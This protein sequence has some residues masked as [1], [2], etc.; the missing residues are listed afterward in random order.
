[1]FDLS[2]KAMERLGKG[3]LRKGASDTEEED[4]VNPLREAMQEAFKAAQEGDFDRYF[5]AFEAAMDIKMAD[6]S[7]SVELEEAEELHDYED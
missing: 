6:V 5:S 2:K 1:M 3:G 4:D 7:S